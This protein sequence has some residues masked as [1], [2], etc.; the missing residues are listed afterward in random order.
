[1]ALL[2]RDRT[3]SPSAKLDAKIKLADQYRTEPVDLRKA[4]PV[5]VDSSPDEF[6]AAGHS[7]K[8]ANDNI[9]EGIN[10]TRDAW[11]D[12]FAD[13]VEGVLYGDLKDVLK[14]W[15]ANWARSG[16]EEAGKALFDM[17][18]SSGGLKGIG[19]AI[20]SIFGGGDK[21]PG[22]KNGGSF[23]V[24]G[25]GGID[26]NL[27]AFRATRGERVDIRTPGQDMGGVGARVIRVVVDKSKLFDV[28]V[29]EAAQ[30]MVAAYSG[31]AAQGGAEMAETNLSARRRKTLGAGR[32]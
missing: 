29:I 18:K 7:L 10:R 3:L 12:A 11:G 31:A 32:R 21:L 14:S 26:N 4:T 22:F 9:V 15:V 17:F 19:Q 27:V 6:K 8:V 30:P 16:L 13:G 5:K 2:D 23:T 20:A 24:G 25:A 1:M 28:A